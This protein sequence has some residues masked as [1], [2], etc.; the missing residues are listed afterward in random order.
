MR[1]SI[2]KC[3]NFVVVGCKSCGSEDGSV[4]CSE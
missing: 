3:G 2:L 1:V 4:F